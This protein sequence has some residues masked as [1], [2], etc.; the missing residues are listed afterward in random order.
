[1]WN[2]KINLNARKSARH[3]QQDMDDAR[4]C[5][6][7][8]AVSCGGQRKVWETGPGINAPPVLRR[9]RRGC[10]TGKVPGRA[11]SGETSIRDQPGRLPAAA[12]GSEAPAAPPLP[13]LRGHFPE[14]L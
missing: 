3:A 6:V 1:M 8:Q 4:R 12:P 14:K 9:A 11:G 5:R 10:R 2:A 13:H 7:G